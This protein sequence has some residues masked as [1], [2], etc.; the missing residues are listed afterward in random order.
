MGELDDD[1]SA[2]S[3]NKKVTRRIENGSVCKENTI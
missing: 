1:S 3:N 2:K